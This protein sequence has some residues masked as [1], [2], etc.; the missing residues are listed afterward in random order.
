MIPPSELPNFARMVAYELHKLQTE[1]KEL[2]SQNEA[3]RMYG[4]AQIQKWK[5]QNRLT[6]TIQGKRIYYKTKQLQKLTL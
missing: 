5:A 4:R 2:I 6:P 1:S 3:F